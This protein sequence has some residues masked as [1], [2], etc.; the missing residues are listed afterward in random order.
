MYIHCQFAPRFALVALV[1]YWAA[2]LSISCISLSRSMFAN[3]VDPYV[4]VDVYYGKVVGIWVI[5]VVSY[6]ST[7][8]KITSPTQ[9]TQG[10]CHWPC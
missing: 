7:G 3:G 9:S 4:L 2:F 10:D 5:P 6:V 1:S 8:Q